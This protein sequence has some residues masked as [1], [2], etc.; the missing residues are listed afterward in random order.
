MA[1]MLVLLSWK[2]IWRN[3][4]RSGVIT[5]SI[6]LGLFGGVF[7]TAFMNGMGRQTVESAISVE[8][9]NIQI[10]NPQ[11]VEEPMAS[12][13]IPGADSVVAALRA[14]PSVKAVAARARINAMIASA[15]TGAGVTVKG[16]DPKEE[17]EISSLPAAIIRGSWFTDEKNNRIVM[18]SKLAEKLDAKL[19]TRVVVTVQDIDGNLTGGAF[20]VEGIFRTHHSTFDENTVFV[21]RSDLSRLIGART[22]AVH[23]IALLL[24]RYQETDSLAG[25]LKTRYPLLSVRSWKELQPEV[26][27]M[28]NLMQQMMYLFVM[29]ILAALSF[30]IVNTM[31]MAVLERRREF[32]MLMAVGMSRPRIFSMVMIETVLLSFTGG[33]TGML[34]GAVAIGITSKTGIDLS[35]LGEGLAAMGYNPLVHPYIE[36]PFF[37]GLCLLVVLTGMGASVYPA[38]KALALKPAD[39]IRSET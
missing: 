18:G 21:K 34:L 24:N 1:D 23:E 10:H 13:T 31:L 6:A 8:L 30:G 35:L 17:R 14:D 12:R 29:I 11:F 36:T 39:A 2:N 33:V 37:I 20:K 7:S 32:G 28:E 15:K 19:K 5:A 4:L 16:I 27:M 9:A 22:D 25:V 38:F 26:G 3:P